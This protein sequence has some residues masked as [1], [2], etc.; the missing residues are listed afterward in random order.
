[1]LLI[2]IH[3]VGPQFY[4]LLKSKALLR[5]QRK[6]LHVCSRDKF[7]ILD[8]S[9]ELGRITLWILPTDLSCPLGTYSSS[10]SEVEKLLQIERARQLGLIWSGETSPSKTNE[11]NMY[12][13]CRL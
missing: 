12:L 7:V 1:M 2:I 11:W 3:W 6:P 8:F 4:I 9:I 10:R 13:L 5:Y